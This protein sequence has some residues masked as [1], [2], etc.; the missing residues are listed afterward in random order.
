[1]LRF[2]RGVALA[3]TPLG[4]R[5]AGDGVENRMLELGRIHLHPPRDVCERGDDQPRLHIEPL[6]VAGESAQ[7]VDD[8]VGLER[9]VFLGEG[10]EGIRVEGDSVLFAERVQELGVQV[11]AATKFQFEVAAVTTNRE[12]A[13][14]HRSAVLDSVVLPFGDADSE[15]H[16]V[17]APCGSQLEALGGDLGGRKLG[18]AQGEVVTDQARQ[19]GALARDELG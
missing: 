9:A 14:Q 15:V 5:V 13:Q 18:T 11:W 3:D 16:G 1:M 4:G 2:D 8:L 10:D 12:R 7:S 19:Q 17:D 6:E